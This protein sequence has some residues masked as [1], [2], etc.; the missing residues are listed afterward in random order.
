ME[1]QTRNLIIDTQFFIKNILDF[2]NLSLQKLQK[3]IQEGSVKLY[4]TDITID[5][6][7]KKIIEL[8]PASFGK[9]NVRDCQYLKVIPA[10][11]KF[12][13]EY[14]NQKL[15]DE[16]Q[17]NFEQFLEN[18]QVHIISSNDVKVLD[19]YKMYTAIKPPF[20][21][22]KKKEFPDAFAL[23][24]IRIWSEKEK[25]SAYLLSQDSDWINYINTHYPPNN[26]KHPSLFCLDDLSSFID[27]IIR[28]D[29]ELEQKVILA[30]AE[31]SEN[32]NSIKKF[33]MRK[34]NEFVFESDGLD[35][36]EVVNTF[37]IDCNL[38]DKDI[39]EVQQNSALYDLSIKI[40]AIVEFKVPN[41]ERAV[42]DSEDQIYYNLK[43]SQIYSK[44]IFD[45]N[46]TID[47]SFDGNFEINGID[48]PAKFIYVPYIEES[49]IIDIDMWTQ[50]L[51]VI[52]CG[53]DDN[54][55]ITKDGSGFIE[56]ENFQKA[57]E[58]FPELEIDTASENFT[59]AL[60]NKITDPLRFESW[61]ALEYYST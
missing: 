9:L 35:D 19:I 12:M 31:F 38:V 55:I 27:S 17:T 39:L 25:I 26:A 2:N 24:A 32:W 10:F 57:K 6:I 42:W 47:F 29:K 33:I 41:Y 46:I 53:V 52:I 8:L 37:L 3:L 44:H 5:E 48:F 36:E 43:Y 13:Q 50:N 11:N 1:L 28:D 56:F 60:G 61:K 40:D 14:N 7:S 21:E 18:C 58:V 45:L 16:V 59:N 54:G 30:D 15:I 4:L 20:S 34:V 22:S 51:P 49:E 23:E